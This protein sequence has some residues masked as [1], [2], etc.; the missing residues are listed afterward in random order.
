MM[1]ITERLNDRRADL[2]NKIL[3]FKQKAKSGSFWIKW[4]YNFLIWEV[5]RQIR[6]I[7]EYLKK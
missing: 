3:Y 4:K 6:I 2:L 1:S 5:N 7:D